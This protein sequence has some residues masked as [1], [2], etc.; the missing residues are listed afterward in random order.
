MLC[1]KTSESSPRLKHRL[2]TLVELADKSLGGTEIPSNLLAGI[3]RAFSCQWA[4]FWEVSSTDGLLCPA[5]LWNE[6][7]VSARQLEQDT[8]SRKLTMSEGTAGHVWRTQRPV[9]TADI[10]KDMCLPRSLHA[11]SAGLEGGVWFAL[12]T[13]DGVYGVIELLGR[14][15]LPATEEAL[16]VV[17]QFGISL[18]RIIESRRFSSNP[19]STPHGATSA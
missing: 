19:T 16:I 2:D 17:E 7:G 8:S 5:K 11:K 10:V 9:W 3:A 4:T 15:P 18:G 14:D 1:M 13:D 12:K 6:D